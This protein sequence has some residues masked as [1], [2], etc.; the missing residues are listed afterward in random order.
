MGAAHLEAI[1]LRDISWAAPPQ[2]IPKTF[3]NR[4]YFYSSG[5][6]VSV[7][8]ELSNGL[9]AG[10]AFCPV[11]G[12]VLGEI[13]RKHALQRYNVGSVLKPSRTGFE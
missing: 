5:S 12:N 13:Y 9:A 1:I 11:L 10:T 7:C 2:G 4:N 3:R 6:R 8:K